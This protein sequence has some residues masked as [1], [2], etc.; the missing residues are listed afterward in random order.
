MTEGGRAAVTVSDEPARSR[1]EDRLGRAQFATLLARAL[2]D[3]PEAGSLVVAL[4][5]P[6]GS[7]KTST[8]N[9]AFEALEEAQGD[10]GPLVLHFDPWWYSDTGELLS[11]FFVQLGEKLGK[12]PS[13]AGLK[14]KLI[15]YGRLTAKPAGALADLA[16]ALGV[17]SA[18]AGGLD[19]YLASL[20]ERAAQDARSLR[21]ELDGELAKL[22][23]GIV[24]V[25]DD[26]DR[27][28]GQE[29]RDVFKL[30]KATANFPNTRYLL[31]FDRTTVAQA[32]SEVQGTDGHAY[33]EK[34]VQLPFA[35]PKPS[36]GLLSDLLLEGVRE[37]A[38]K[39][40][41][42]ADDELTATLGKFE[43]YRYKG[44]DVLFQSVRQVKRL[45][46]MLRFT[47]PP[48]AGEVKLSDFLT[49][50]MLRLLYPEAYDKLVELQSLLVGVPQRASFMDRRAGE[51]KE[52]VSGA[53][54]EVASAAG[55]TGQ[56]MV[57]RWM[58]DLFP[59]VEA[60]N[61][62]VGWSDDFA[63]EWVSEKRVCMPDFFRIATSW[64]LVP[65]TISEQELR[66]VLVAKDDPEQLRERI[67]AYGEDGRPGVDIAT[68]LRRL[69]AWYRTNATADDAEVFLRATF[70][71]EGYGDAQT[72]LWVL[73][74]DLIEKLPDSATRKELLLAAI[75][76]HGATTTLVDV[77][78]ALGR[79][80]H[81]YRERAP[82]EDQHRKI[83]AADFGEVERA[84]VTDIER[85]ARDRSVL[86]RDLF[87]RFFY[88][89]E[90]VSGAEDPK[91][92][93]AEMIG[94]DRLLARL[95]DAY[96]RRSDGVHFGTVEESLAKSPSQL[97][98][99]LLENFG[100]IG[101]ARGRAVVLLE[102]S[103]E[104]LSDEDRT[105]LQAFITFHGE[106]GEAT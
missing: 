8:L 66:E 19:A 103:P 102:A 48:V 95:L 45:L 14:N 17:G 38:V 105:L 106:G 64:G 99:Q 62:N 36:P 39:Q 42:I 86:D 67:L 3:Y 22:E 5:G 41:R 57:T 100:L 68:L 24:V 84:I 72:T 74:T 93:L 18:M 15:K 71:I 89:W 43:Y 2:V 25:I 7:G 10:G 13:R 88:Q 90:A 1:G 59:R 91:E 54:A 46:G 75:D 37:V 34:I 11:Q 78:H 98:V 27:L 76:E 9:F 79:D 47:L 28:S 55:V 53:A 96:A 52:A 81:G 49:L 6:W 87:D 77:V 29:T 65:G 101:D 4:Y 31:A 33:L 30:V 20:Q 32:L 16:G 26:I 40:D 44:L 73:G 12:D 51:E 60:A 70:G 69:G 21:A 83:S 35:L 61:R 58:E 63:Y 82:L 50:E 104:W 23:R 94:D 56:A 97:R 85:Q 92:S 80:E